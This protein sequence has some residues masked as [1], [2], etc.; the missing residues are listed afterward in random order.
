MEAYVTYRKGELPEVWEPF[1]EKLEGCIQCGVCSGSCPSVE[2]MDLTPRQIIHLLRLGREDEALSANTAWFC[3]VCYSCAVRCPAG[4]EIT[5]IMAVLRNRAIQ[6]GVA[7]PQGLRASRA[8]VGQIAR[9][10][11]VFEPE[12]L[13]RAKL[14]RPLDLLKDVSLG[15]TL[16]RKG[17]VSL[18]PD[19][20]KVPEALK[21]SI[22]R[23][24]HAG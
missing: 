9:Y 16:L 14:T 3:A 10:G 23:K 20:V 2:A 18:K 21:E 4:I 5:D 6:K 1:R 11:R 24:M 12:L 19:I 17:K 7:E 8:F 13:L 22:G 15:L